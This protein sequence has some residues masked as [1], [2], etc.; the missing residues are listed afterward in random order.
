MKPRKPSSP[1]PVRKT[2]DRVISKAGL[3]SRSDARS[4]IGQGRV[5]VNGRVIRTPDHWVFPERDT[6][7]ID[8]EPLRAKRRQYIL[9]YKPKDVITS[10]GD[11]QGRRTIYDLISDV[12]EWLAPVGRL[13]QDTTGLLI[14]TNDND[15]ADMMMDPEFHVPKTYL[16]KTS[17]HLGAEDL[18]RLRNGLVLSDGPTRPAIVKHLRDTASATVIEITLTEG[19]NRQVRRMIEAVGSR[20]RKLV[21]VAIGPV[22]IGDLEIGRWRELTSREVESLRQSVGRKPR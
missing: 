4:W 16:V 11:P 3:A 6:V 7:T 20:V 17:T 18:D 1:E 12:G 9:L 22:T 5:A 15:F 8:G 10:H 14:L 2:L 19:R 13:D 21:R